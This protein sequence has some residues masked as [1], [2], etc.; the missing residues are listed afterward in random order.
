MLLEV[1]IYYTVKWRIGNGSTTLR[2]STQTYSQGTTKMKIPL[3]ILQAIATHCRIKT[4]PHFR[5]KERLM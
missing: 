3:K 1:G 2:G 4:E 5:G